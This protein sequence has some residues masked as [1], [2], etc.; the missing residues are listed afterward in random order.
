MTAHDR[1][2]R[3]HKQALSLTI[4]LVPILDEVQRV[5]D[6]RLLHERVHIL[7]LLVRAIST[8]TVTLQQQ[9]EKA[10][11]GTKKC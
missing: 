8:W 4:H 5:M 6:L 2:P 7:M 11:K 1:I 9:M 3:A 10:K